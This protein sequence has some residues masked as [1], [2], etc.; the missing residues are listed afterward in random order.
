M[1]ETT[2]IYGPKSQDTWGDSKII[3][4]YERKER[5]DGIIN[6]DKENLG[7]LRFEAKMWVPGLF[8]YYQLKALKEKPTFDDMTTK[9]KRMEYA[10]I[11]FGE[12][13]LD[14]IKL[15]AAGALYAIYKL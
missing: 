4:K 13:M 10:S 7:S 1:E 6:S 12:V 3:D 11:I 5:N 8:T 9:E 2:S 15:G 14:V